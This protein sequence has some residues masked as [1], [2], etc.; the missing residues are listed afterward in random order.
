LEHGLSNR[1][2]PARDEVSAGDAQ[3][4]E[5]NVENI[6]DEGDG[7]YKAHRIKDR[8]SPLAV[9]RRAQKKCACS[10]ILCV[11]ND[12]VYLKTLVNSL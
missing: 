1:A 6:E 9:G 11:D 10:D 7:E 2:L 8:G 5:E 3:K 12:P 4:T